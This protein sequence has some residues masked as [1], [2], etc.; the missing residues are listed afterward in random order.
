MLTLIAPTHTARTLTHTHTDHTSSQR[1][2]TSHANCTYIP[3]HTDHTHSL[4]THTDHTYTKHILLHTTL[5]NR[6]T[7]SPTPLYP[8]TLTHGGPISVPEAEALRDSERGREDSKDRE[9]EKR[10][11]G[12]CCQRGKWL[13]NQERLPDGTGDGSGEVAAQPSMG[14]VGTAAA[15]APWG[16]HHDVVPS[17]LRL[18]CSVEICQPLWSPLS[19]SFL[20]AT[21]PGG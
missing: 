20:P 15:S 10:W 21:P 14:H 19:S 8:H 4:T 2:H 1:S 13:W 7:T 18:A 6:H 5:T 11:T 17:P 12:Q 9:A 16:S 3:M